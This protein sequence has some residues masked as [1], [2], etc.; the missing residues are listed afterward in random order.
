MAVLVYVILF[1]PSLV[2][3]SSDHD[4][5][6]IYNLHVDCKVTSRFAHTVITSRIANKANVSKEAIFEV[7]LP[8]T[9]FITNFSMIIDGVTYVGTVKEKE[10]AQQQYDTAVSQGQSAGLVKVSG[11]K[12]EEFK[13]GINVAASKKVTFQLTYEELLK[14]HSGKYE[15]H[16]RVQPK[17]LV[18]KF[19]I[20]V[21]ITEPLGISFLTTEAPFLNE[22]LT[23]ALSKT[24]NDKEAYISFNPT[25][26]QQRI[27]A[28]CEE[29]KINGDFIVKY[30]VNR[31]IAAGDIQIVN[32]Y[33]V[34]YFAPETLPKLP[35]NVIFVIDVSG[36]M[37]GRKI[38]QTRE[39]LLRILSDMHSD[40]RFN[41]I[42]FSS[43]VSTWKTAVVTG[44]TS[45]I[46]N[47]KRHVKGIHARGGTNI[48][49]AVLEA[50]NMLDDAEKKEIL[51][52][53]SASIIILLTDGAPTSGVTDKNEI[54]KNVKNAIKQ[55]YTLYCLGFGYDVD[56]D[57]LEAMALENGGVARRI[58]EDSDSD[59]QLQ[60][61]Y[62]E[63]AT[64][65]LSDIKFLY[66]ENAV[67]SLTTN[68][69]RHYYMGSEIVVAGH[70][71][72][73]SLD[74]LAVQINARAS[75][76]DLVLNTTASVQGMAGIL[77]NQ[78]YIFGEYTERLWA[79]LTIQQL[80]EQIIS[81]S[82]LQK[83]LLTQ[84]ALELS[85]KY[86]FVTSLTSMVVTKP[87]EG[88]DT[89]TM[90]ADKPKDEG[91]KEEDTI[92]GFSR[93]KALRVMN[94]R[95]KFTVFGGRSL[96]PSLSDQA[97]DTEIISEQLLALG[98]RSRLGSY[99]DQ[100]IH[101]EIMSTRRIHE[102]CIK[103]RLQVNLMSFS[104]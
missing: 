62:N 52:E 36:S 76:N 16:I 70:I 29:T 82:P 47:A 99:N 100:V 73:N 30:D 102:I 85:L 56:Y 46:E 61:F 34:H 104:Y 37:S 20:D 97:L 10:A 12:M 43:S 48:N 11:R 67:S 15:I 71:E 60:G 14:R 78:T 103:M 72:D 64:P 57:L 33:F 93:G 23:K 98:G 28:K 92:S 91:K 38:E 84:K 54:R 26:Q 3:V 49:D 31:E 88:E 74:V 51:P 7:E 24:Q 21:Y 44:S 86:N 25:L 75:Q 68:I 13:V 101:K 89:Q 35:K 83:E 50:V 40:D 94:Q 9:A 41:L 22:N 58:Y 1:L 81:A 4:D 59:L 8:K 27:C 42:T 90:L 96:F 17:Q 77:K 53:R 18:K 5:I 39:A 95:R 65:I 55:R 79:Y 80:L 66:S 2:F 69:F 45:H 6:D 87:T 63:I 19:K 32:G